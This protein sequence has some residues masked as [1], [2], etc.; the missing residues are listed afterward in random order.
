MDR[1]SQGSVS[2][3]PQNLDVHG[4]SIQSGL[5]QDHLRSVW[6]GQLATSRPLCEHNRTWAYPLLTQLGIGFTVIRQ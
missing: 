1:L 6:T 5:V 2:A 3:D 4:R